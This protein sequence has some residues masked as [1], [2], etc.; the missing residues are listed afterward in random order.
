MSYPG[1]CNNADP[2]RLRKASSSPSKTLLHGADEVGGEDRVAYM[3][4]L[5]ARIHGDGPMV[6]LRDRCGASAWDEVAGRLLV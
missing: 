6:L 5:L 2:A 1:T 4:A 3:V